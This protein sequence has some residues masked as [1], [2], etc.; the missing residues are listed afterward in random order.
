[1]VPG[2]GVPIGVPSEAASGPAW[3][4]GAA[5]EFDLGRPVFQFAPR[6]GPT[7]ECGWRITIGLL[8]TVRDSLQGTR[9]FVGDQQAADSLSWVKASL[10][11]TRELLLGLAVVR[12]LAAGIL[13]GFERFMHAAAEIALHT[14]SKRKARVAELVAQA[15]HGLPCLG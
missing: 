10:W 1:M 11:R 12:T 7:R 8:E 9:W 15:V 14:G 13:A 2:V 4:K 3:S 6:R 5:C